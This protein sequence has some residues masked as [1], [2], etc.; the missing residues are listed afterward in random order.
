MIEARPDMY[1]TAAFLMDR[2][3][4]CYSIREGLDLKKYC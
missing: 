2:S 4:L 3:E 1:N